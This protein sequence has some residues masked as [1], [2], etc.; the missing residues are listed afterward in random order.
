MNENYTVLCVKQSFFFLYEVIEK[1]ILIKLSLSVFM[2]PKYTLLLLG[3]NN[4]T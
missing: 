3:T 2:A 1:K 4:F